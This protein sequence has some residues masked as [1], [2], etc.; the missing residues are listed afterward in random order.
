MPGIVLV[1]IFVTEERSPLIG[2]AAGVVSLMLVHVSA[3]AR[4]RVAALAAAAVGVVLLFPGSQGS[5][6]RSF[7]TNSITP[8]SSAG[9][10]I[11]YRAGLVRTGW[12]AFTLRP[13]LGWSY[14]STRVI[15]ENP[16]LSSIMVFQNKPVTDVAVWPLAILVQMGAIAFV[17]FIGLVC[18]T[19]YRLATGYILENAALARACMA[20]LIASFV[21]SFGVT[22]PASTTIFFFA[23][24]LYAAGSQRV[25]QLSPMRNLVA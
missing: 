25:E 8:G 15:S 24:G 11:S 17:V 20:G 6:F 9:Q 13:L 23:M 22:E 16:L 10:D 19:V 7:L 1:G 21:T 14:G 12:H 4:L 5:K 2:I 3:R 18:C